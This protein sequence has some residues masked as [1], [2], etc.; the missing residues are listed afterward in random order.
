M[1]WQKEKIVRE[2]A[3]KIKKEIGI[4]TYCHTKLKIDRINYTHALYIH[5]NS[6]GL[7]YIISQTF[8]RTRA[9]YTLQSA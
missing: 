1:L 4:K 8:I 2:K 3:F 7:E 5:E 9:S 6:V